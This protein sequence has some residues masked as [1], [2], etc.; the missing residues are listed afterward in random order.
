MS[1]VIW[2]ITQ[3]AESYT[4]C[5]NFGESLREKY[6][7]AG[8]D[9]LL[10][11]VNE[12]PQLN[13]KLSIIYENIA[14]TLSSLYDEL[15]VYENGWEYLE[16]GN[17]NLT[18]IYANEATRKV[19]TNKEEYSNYDELK[20]NIREM[21]SGESASCPTLITPFISR[22]IGFTNRSLIIIAF[23]PQSTSLNAR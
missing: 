22:S 23:S 10:Q 20:N 15:L 5:W 7:P 12:T 19:V 6:A 2:L 3:D 21:K 14:S 18:Y 1:N 17:T 13:G 11:V 4:D 8:A 16:E 9:N